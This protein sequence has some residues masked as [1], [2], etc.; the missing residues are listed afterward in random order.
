MEITATGITLGSGT[1]SLAPPVLGGT[2]SSW[3]LAAAAAVVSF[4]CFSV[5]GVQAARD[6][7]IRTVITPI[8]H[9]FIIVKPP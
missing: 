4:F 9:F 2:I 6:T 5:V 1:L 8:N 3:D 7:A